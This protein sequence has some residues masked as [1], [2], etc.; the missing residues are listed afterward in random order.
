V[1]LDFVLTPDPLHGRLGNSQ[2]EQGSP[3]AERMSELVS[4]ASA[5][6]CERAPTS[7][8]GGEARPFAAYLRRRVI[9]CRPAPG[10]M[11]V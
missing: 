8:R 2:L 7:F 3:C 11:L 6:N 10:I 1:G 5:A 4:L 9:F